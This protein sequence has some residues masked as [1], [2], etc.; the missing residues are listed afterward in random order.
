MMMEIKEKEISLR[1]KGTEYRKV[2]NI[3][4]VKEVNTYVKMLKHSLTTQQP[5]TDTQNTSQDIWFTK[6]TF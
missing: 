2:K 5:L 3:K 6:L 4:L 1:S